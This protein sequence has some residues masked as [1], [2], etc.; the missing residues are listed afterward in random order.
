MYTQ[1]CIHKYTHT[2]RYVCGEHEEMVL[3]GHKCTVGMASVSEPQDTEEGAR[4]G[5]QKRASGANSAW[6]E[7]GQAAVTQAKK[8]RRPKQDTMGVS[9]GLQVCV[10]ASLHVCVHVC[11][12]ELVCVCV[13]DTCMH[14]SV[15]C[16]CVCARVQLYVNI[17]G[18]FSRRQG[19]RDPE[20]CGRRPGGRCHTNSSGWSHS[21]IA[22]RSHD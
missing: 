6:E 20:A 7:E 8:K 15:F 12:C 2:D 19:Y 18:F 22:C 10:R 21:F 11:A 1:R 5:K 3:A 17:A 4:H 13:I 16:V 9:Q 14:A